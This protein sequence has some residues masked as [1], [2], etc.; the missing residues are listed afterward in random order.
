M[1]TGSPLSDTKLMLMNVG[2][3]AIGG[4]LAMVFLTNDLY[5]PYKQLYCVVK[6]SSYHLY[7]T[8]PC[9][10]VTFGAIDA[11]IYYY[12]QSYEYIIK[13]QKSVPRDAE[14]LVKR[15]FIQGC[16]FY[17]LWSIVIIVGEWVVIIVMVVIVVLQ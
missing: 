14:V 17:L 9:F 3:W 5:G 1:V 12:Y 2:A 7:A 16:V 13:N 11:M 6:E 15:G 10:V 4:A 8:L